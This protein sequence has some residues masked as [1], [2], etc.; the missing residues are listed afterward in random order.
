M[1][2]WRQKNAFNDANSPPF[3][4]L[5]KGT[6][7]WGCRDDGNN[8]VAVQ[9]GSCS[10]AKHTF[11]LQCILSRRLLSNWEVADFISA[12]SQ[13]SLARAMIWPNQF[14]IHAEKRVDQ[15]QGTSVW[16][17]LDWEPTLEPLLWKGPQP[18]KWLPQD[19]WTMTFV[20]PAVSFHP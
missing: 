20:T 19:S 17:C 5:K 18:S 3:S 6:I 7:G 16:V 10:K 14:C 1:Y 4:T 2:F 9:F 15:V 13:P 8:S 11:F 12:R